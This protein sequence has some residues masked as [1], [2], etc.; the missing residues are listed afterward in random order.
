MLDTE[1]RHL[2]QEVRAQVLTIIGQAPT[3]PSIAYF[4]FDDTLYNSS[5]RNLMCRGI[6]ILSA[7]VYAGIPVGL[8]TLRDIPAV[9]RVFRSYPQLETIFQSNPYDILTKESMLNWNTQAHGLAQYYRMDYI[10]HPSKF[11]PTITVRL[12]AL[13]VRTADGIEKVDVPK[14]L[15]RDNAVLFDDMDWAAE[16]RSIQT[17]LG[18]RIDFSSSQDP[19]AVAARRTLAGFV[20][21]PYEKEPRPLN[22]SEI[23]A[24]KSALRVT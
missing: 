8:F 17:L 22:H 21:V 4:D 11:D 13:A 2:G 18:H 16:I 15:T 23:S 3:P 20:R 10:D 19:L 9:Q 6:G 1:D 12:P 7:F 14:L 5:R 24:I